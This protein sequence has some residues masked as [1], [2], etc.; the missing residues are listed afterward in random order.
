MLTKEECKLIE[1]K[2]KIAQQKCDTGKRLEHAFRAW[3]IIA[4][5]LFYSLPNG[6]GKCF[7]RRFR[8]A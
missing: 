7:E 4:S 5:R 8:A 3:N 1:I 6:K 2:P